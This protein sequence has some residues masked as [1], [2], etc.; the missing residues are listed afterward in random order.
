MLVVHALNT[1]AV[2]TTVHVRVTRLLLYY[3]STHMHT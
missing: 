2:I 1:C 3:D